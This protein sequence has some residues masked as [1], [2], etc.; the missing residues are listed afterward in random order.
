MAAETAAAD[1]VAI[2]SVT[3]VAPLPAGIVEGENVA[4]AP[5]G[6]IDITASVTGFEVV[7]FEG[8]TIKM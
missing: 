4:V 6:N 7:L 8:V 2:E 5:A 1:V 3:V